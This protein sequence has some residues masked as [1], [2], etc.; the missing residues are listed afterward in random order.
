M[1]TSASADRLLRRDYYCPALYREI[2]CR[3]AKMPPTAST[4]RHLSRLLAVR[5]LTDFMWVCL[6]ELIPS[7]GRSPCNNI[8]CSHIGALSSGGVQSKQNT[9]EI[10][11]EMSACA[12]PLPTSF[13]AHIS[14]LFPVG[15]V[16]A[17]IERTGDRTLIVCLRSPPPADPT[18][19][20]RRDFGRVLQLYR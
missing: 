12:D 14:T 8:P 7:C 11:Y 9:L 15:V 5:Q 10:A 2:I 19:A 20:Q 6:L 18:R 4:T 1:G 3:T 16:Q 17:K 13:V